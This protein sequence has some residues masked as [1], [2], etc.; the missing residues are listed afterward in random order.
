MSLRKEKVKDV[1][2]LVKKSFA[3]VDVDISDTVLDRAHRAGAFYKHESDQSIQGIIV[4]FNN[5]RYRS[6]FYKNRKKLKQGKHVRIDLISNH[7]NLLKKANALIKLMKMEN[8]VYTFADI[9]CRLKVVN[10]KNWEDL[11]FSQT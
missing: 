8:T 1:I 2:N 3:E 11:F 4:K 7:Y 10:K 9:N 5:F 6:M